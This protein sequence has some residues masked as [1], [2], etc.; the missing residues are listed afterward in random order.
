MF[1]IVY[2]IW[3]NEN[4]WS[5]YKA[6]IKST[7]LE[8]RWTTRS[9]FE[10]VLFSKTT[11]YKET[12]S[13]WES[14]CQEETFFATATGERKKQWNPSQV[15]Y[16]INFYSRSIEKYNVILFNVYKFTYI[17]DDTFDT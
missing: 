15:C 11:S 14:S 1:P 10:E 5:F 12:I 16:A 3:Y 7:L 6:K 9:S 13:K 8:A 4:V 2:P 17:V